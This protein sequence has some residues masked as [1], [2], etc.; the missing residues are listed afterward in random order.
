VSQRDRAIV[1]VR[2][3]AARLVDARVAERLVL[4]EI[5][6]IDVPPPLG[7]IGGPPLYFRILASGPAS[8]RVE[9][10]EL[11]APRGARSV[12]SAGSDNLRARRIALAA[13]ELTRQLERRRRSEIE[14]ASRA[15]SGGPR[16]R[17]EEKGIPL[18]ARFALEAGGRAGAIGP[19][20]AWVAGPWLGVG[21]GFTSGF[22][23]SLGAG[24]LVGRAPEVGGATRWLDA[25]LSATQRIV[26]RPAFRLS[27]GAEAS[28]ASV[29]VDDG[30]ELGVTPPL[31]T[32]SARAGF[33]ARGALP[34]GRVVTVLFGP[35]VGFVLRPIRGFAADGSARSISGLWVGGTIT[36]QLEP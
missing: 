16:P 22:R 2:S 17:A 28:V 3:D 21:L 11:G 32:W 9:L 13:G 30:H 12:A 14:A 36:V 1:E 8:L 19:S 5:D 10:W 15:P 29:R 6:D 34:L 7:S 26:N 25:G 24:W 18:Y 35:D 4:L 23:L 33:V 20:T 31:D 27:A